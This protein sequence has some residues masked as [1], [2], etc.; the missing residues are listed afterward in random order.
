MHNLLSEYPWLET[1]WQILITSYKNNQ[2]SHAQLML[3]PQGLGQISLVNIIA[4]TLLCSDKGNTPCGHCKSCYLCK[5]D[6]HPD[7]YH[8]SIEEKANTLKIDQIRKILQS[9]EDMSQLSGAKVV[10]IKEADKMTLN[11]ANALL[12][13]LEEPMKNTYFILLA[14]KICAIPK[15]IISRCA[16]HILKQPSLIQVKS[17]LNAQNLKTDN[18]EILYSLSLGSPEAIKFI[19]EN[20]SFDQIKK[21]LEELLSFLQLKT[22]LNSAI[23]ELLLLPSNIRW[24]LLL[25]WLQAYAKKFFTGYL[26]ND[27]QVW[28][29]F[30]PKTQLLSQEHAFKI[31]EHCLSMIAISSKTH[32]N[33]QLLFENILISL[34]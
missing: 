22:S 14:E 26:D 13:R 17:W 11:A 28:E 12:K 5:R 31:H 27:V 33:E 9:T 25:G 3:G 4:Q 21:A 16:Y 2:F 6:L 34:L 1:T 29:P 18:I 7:L 10:V 32:L 23:K 24:N 20:V 8:I 30:L 19:L 15:T